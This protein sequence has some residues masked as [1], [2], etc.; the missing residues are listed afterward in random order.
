MQ[1]DV[2]QSVEY[3]YSLFFIYIAQ[4][5]LAQARPPNNFQQQ[6]LVVPDRFYDGGG[7]LTPHE[8]VLLYPHHLQYAMLLDKSFFDLSGETCDR[9]GVAW[10]A[11]KYQSEGCERTPGDCV[12]NQIENF[13]EEDT[14]RGEEN[15]LYFVKRYCDG[16]M[17][18]EQVVDD[19]G[20]IV[21]EYFMCPIDQRHTTMVRL[22]LK[23]DQMRFVS[24]VG[25][26]VIVQV[27]VKDFEVSCCF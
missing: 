2:W 25:K 16:L 21:D 1:I 14:A 11:F 4:G 15:P 27:E 5:D 17:E 12:K 23:A 24:N 18:G 6:Y 3:Q 10:T 22:E 19:A 7:K 8:R 9:I 26:A 13:H 20:Y